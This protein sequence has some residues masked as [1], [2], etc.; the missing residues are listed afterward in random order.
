MQEQKEI[1]GQSRSINHILKLI[2]L[3]AKL[4]IPILITGESGCGKELVAQ[5]IHRQSSRATEPFMPINIGAIPD[6]LITSELFGH[7]KGSFTG[8]VNLKKGL[9]EAAGNGTLFLDEIGTMDVNTQVSLLR[10]L[11][12]RTFFRVGGT[13]MLRSHAR[14]IAATN[15]NLIKAIKMG[16][17]RLDLYYRLNGFTISVPPL[18]ERK[19]DIEFLAHYFLKKY[20]QEFNRKF[21]TLSD[22]ALNIFKAYSWPGNVR[23]LENVI[24]QVVIMGKGDTIIPRFLPEDLC[25]DY[26]QTTK[27]VKFNIGT[28]L[29]VIKK[30]L[31]VRTLEDVKWNKQAASRILG[32]SR[33]SMYNNLKKYCINSE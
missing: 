3:V 14:I 28:S 16:N 15:E 19:E 30:E 25:S 13:K 9:F 18:R 22:A 5:S 24:K 26:P 17:F 11:E 8:A 7:E 12:T 2:N 21:T 20:N 1:K 31:L 23:E 32:I 33:K 29:E 6:E 27:V 10:F 4:D